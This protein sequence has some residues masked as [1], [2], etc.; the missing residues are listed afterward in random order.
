MAQ[1]PVQPDQPVQSVQ[2]V[3]PIQPGKPDLQINVAQLRER[4]E[5]ELGAMRRTANPGAWR[6]HAVAADVYRAKLRHLE[7]IVAAESRS[8]DGE[9]GNPSGAPN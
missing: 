8:G 6:A 9:N 5:R 1:N 2:P 7:S 3:H 4:L